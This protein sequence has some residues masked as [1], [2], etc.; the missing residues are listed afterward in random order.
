MHFYI[1]NL[2]KQEEYKKNIKIKLNK[3]N[4]KNIN[5]ENENDN[6]SR[7]TVNSM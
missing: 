1:E 5:I 2:L 3:R 4:D 7:Q 6:V